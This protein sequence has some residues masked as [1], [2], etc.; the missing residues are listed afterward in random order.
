MRQVR[1]TQT[2]YKIL[3]KKEVKYEPFHVE[4]EYYVT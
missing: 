2:S 1:P 4:A 3:W